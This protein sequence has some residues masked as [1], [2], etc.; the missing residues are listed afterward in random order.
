MMAGII[1]SFIGSLILGAGFAIVSLAFGSHFAEIAGTLGRMA[2]FTL[3]VAV[4]GATLVFDEATIGLM[5]GGLQLARNVAVSIA[6]MAALPACAL[7]L[8]DVLG[9]GIMLAWVLG[10]LALAAS[11]H[12]HDQAQRLAQSCT[13][14][15]GSRSARLRKVSLSHNWLNLAITTPLKLVPVL[16]VIVVS[17]ASNAAY[18]VASMLASFLFMVPIHLS[19]V[20]F[21]IASAA[22]EHDRGEAAL[23]ARACH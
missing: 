5:R 21:A 16:V 17:P 14:R 18:Y 9:V 2:I 10:T 20:L 15:T 22:P 13:G 19:T 11:R 12:P 1:A 3:G 23:R 4:T 6:K 7:I 8:H